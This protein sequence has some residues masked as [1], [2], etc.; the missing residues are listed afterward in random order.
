MSLFEN[1]V[2][3]NQPRQTYSEVLPKQAAFCR[4]YGYYMFIF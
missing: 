3:G 2:S 4:R 1:N